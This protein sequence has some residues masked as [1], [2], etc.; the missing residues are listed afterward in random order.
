M[1]PLASRLVDINTNIHTPIHPQAG[2]HQ[3]R[4][5]HHYQYRPTRPHY[6]SSP[7]APPS[8]PSSN[9]AVYD[10]SSPLPTPNQHYP[11]VSGENVT[12][13]EVVMEREEE[14]AMRRYEEMNRQLGE[15][16]VARR[17]RWGGD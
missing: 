2:N 6:T 12:M 15:F 5:A 17:E 11:P 8:F 10:P 4:L 9:D 16:A 1:T 7:F 14:E 13:G 3:S